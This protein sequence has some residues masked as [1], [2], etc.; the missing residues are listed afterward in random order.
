MLY[1]WPGER[2]YLLSMLSDFNQCYVIDSLLT[3]NFPLNVQ[4]NRKCLQNM[5][6]IKL[7]LWEKHWP[8]IRLSRPKGC[9][10]NST[11]G[12]PKNYFFSLHQEISVEKLGARCRFYLHKKITGA[13]VSQTDPLNLSGFYGELI[14]CQQKRHLAYA[15]HILTSNIWEEKALYCSVSNRNRKF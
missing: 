13:C 14:D 6:N 2:K 3:N 5:E 15:E 1:P 8:E 4:N 11:K 10:K 7:F 9:Q 12:P